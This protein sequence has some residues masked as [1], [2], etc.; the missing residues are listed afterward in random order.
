[1]RW[2]LPAG[3]SATSCAGVGGLELCRPVLDH[4]Q[5][6]VYLAHLVV[7]PGQLIS[8]IICSNGELILGLL[9]IR[10]VDPLLRMSEGD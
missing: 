7:H 6:G 9:I 10:S 8:R 2:R 5:G 1:M 3:L 4:R